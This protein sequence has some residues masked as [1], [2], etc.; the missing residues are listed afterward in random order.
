ME[1]VRSVVTAKIVRERHAL[2]AQRGQFFTTG[3]QFIIKV[4]CLIGTL[5]L[6]FRHVGSS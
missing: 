6:L 5:C 3:F 4:N 2:L 1:L